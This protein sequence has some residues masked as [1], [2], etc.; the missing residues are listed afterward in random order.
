[1]ENKP[2]GDHGKT[3]SQH[4]RPRQEGCRGRAGPLD[5]ADLAARLPKATP[6]FTPGVLKY[7]SSMQANLWSAGSRS[8]C[9]PVA[10]TSG[11]EEQ[12]A[13]TSKEL[14]TWYP[15]HWSFQIWSR[16]TMQNPITWSKEKNKEKPNSDS[17]LYAGRA[18]E[19]YKSPNP[20]TLEKSP[21]HRGERY[22]NGDPAEGLASGG[23]AG[24]VG[25]GLVGSL[26][27]GSALLAFLAWGRE[28]T[29][30]AETRAKPS[31]PPRQT[32]TCPFLPPNPL[33]PARRLLPVA[34][35]RR[36]RRLRF[37]MPQLPSRLPASVDPKKKKGGGG[38]ID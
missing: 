6:F 21:P 37:L 38:E 9:R 14:L 20:Q 29:T 15:C 23:S 32:W 11:T 3:T 17:F 35:H 31:S 7:S 2:N 12:G 13:S 27:G 19:P 33:D 36:R 5:T 22:S 25:G 24:A 4:P 28:P 1:M 26:G 10:C 16:T 8:S 30:T 18:E 34:R